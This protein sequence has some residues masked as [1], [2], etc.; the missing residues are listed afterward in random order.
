MW[1]SILHLIFNTFVGF[2]YLLILG[3]KIC[4]LHLLLLKCPLLLGKL[5]F[6]IILFCFNF[7]FKLNFGVIIVSGVVSCVEFVPGK[8]G[9]WR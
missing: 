1:Y 9:L 4:N 5:Y 6:F 2:L 3:Y 7:T 8:L